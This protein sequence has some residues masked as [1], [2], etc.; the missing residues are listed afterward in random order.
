M[1]KENIENEKKDLKNETNVYIDEAKN[2]EN[3][4]NSKENKREGEKRLEEA[5]KKA[6]REKEQLAKELENLKNKELEE[7]EEFKTLYEKTKSDLKNLQIRSQ[8]SEVLS[9]ES[10]NPEFSKLIKR[11]VENNVQDIENIDTETLKNIVNQLKTEY[12]SAFTVKKAKVNIGTDIASPPKTAG[13]SME[14]ALNI[15]NSGDNIAFNTH[16]D[17]IEKL[18][19]GL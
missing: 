16:K 7:K 6:N 15:V 3:D 13:L 10:I 17:E 12:P 2:T 1:N 9:E 14:E 5:L 19:S 11:E 18:L 4:E 8:I